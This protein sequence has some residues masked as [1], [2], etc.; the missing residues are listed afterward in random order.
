M[1]T[2]ALTRIE[3]D[4]TNI[5]DHCSSSQQIITLFAQYLMGQ[6]HLGEIED[7]DFL[8]PVFTPTDTHVTVHIFFPWDITMRHELIVKKPDNPHQAWKRA[9]GVI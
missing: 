5:L 3:D 6:F 9:I 4:L 7:Y 8:M 1:I 2:K